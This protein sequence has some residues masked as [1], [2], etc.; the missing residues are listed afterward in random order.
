MSKDFPYSPNKIF[1]HRKWIDSV[2]RG[3]FPPPIFVE[4]LPT[5]RCNHRCTFCSYRNQE[6]GSSQRFNPK[7]EIPFKKLAEIVEDCAEMGVKAIEVTGGGEPMM[8][9]QFLDLCRLIISKGL[10]LGLVTN[11]SWWTDEATEVLKDAAWVRISID[12]GCKKT[13]EAVRRCKPRAYDI[14]R[15]AIRDLSSIKQTNPTPI[16]GVGF[17]VMQDNYK[18]IEHAVARA[19]EDGADNIRISAVFQEKGA[20]YFESFKEETQQQCRK[21]AGEYSNKDFTVFNLFDDRLTD[22]SAGS[23]DYSTCHFQQASTY[24]GADQHVYRCCVLGYNDLGFLGSLKQQRFKDM[25]NRPETREAI[26]E[27]NPRV[28]PQ[29]MFNNKNRSIN[30]ALQQNPLHVNFI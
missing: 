1:H 24:I 13:Y 7:D 29:C 16:I 21:I 18:D 26:W 9:P 28:C 30:Y 5:N 27:F 2:R 11:G 3:E 20:A 14:V 25:W 8:H 17:V 23:P 4:I 19:R 10:D 12:A 22:L 15:Q 6:Y